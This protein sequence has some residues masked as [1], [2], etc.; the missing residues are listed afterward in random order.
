MAYAT[1]ERGASQNG[2]FAVPVEGSSFFISHQQFS[3][4]GLSDK[5]S[6][7]EAEFF[8]LRTKLLGTQCRQ[9]AMDYLASREHSRQEL[10]LKLLRK[11]FPKDVI[12]EELS[13][14]EDERLLS[15]YRFAEQFVI[16]RQR[17]NPEGI[18]LLRMRLAQKG[19][20]REIAEAV[21]T[22]WFAEEGATEDALTRAAE[23]IMRRR[24]IGRE[25][26]TANL[27][28]KGFSYSEVSH[29]LNDLP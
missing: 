16:S 23:K 7:S 6:L 27:L 1:I 24:E 25:K 10:A 17:K 11:N 29:F 18:S 8:A 3:Q 15:D 12:N 20:S 22:A 19:V 4:L 21:C 28:R 2:Y 13:R 5:Q 26:L 14:L 9:K